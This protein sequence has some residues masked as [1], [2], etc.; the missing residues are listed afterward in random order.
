M[1]RIKVIQHL[2]V[3]LMAL[4]VA[5]SCGSGTDRAKEGQTEES[6]SD[7][8]AYTFEKFL[9]DAKNIQMNAA[10]ISSIHQYLVIARVDYFQEICNPP[11]NVN[12]YMDSYPFAAANLGVYFADLIYHTYARA[13]ENTANTTD[14]ILELADYI[15][16]ENDLYEGLVARYADNDVPIDSTLMY[17]NMLMKDSEKYGSESEKVFVKSAILLGNN[18]EKWYLVSTLIQIPFRR[19]IS[20]DEAT[21]A[22]QELTYF[23]MNLENRVDVLLKMAVAQRDQLKSV[24]LIEELEKLKQAATA[25]TASGDQILAL[26]APGIMANAEL[27]KLHEQLSVIRKA[28]ILE[29]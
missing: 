23:M 1:N 24:F 15:G 13:T 26:D 16:L 2:A 5:Y 10:S 9:E 25:V 29:Q 8:S 11:E 14:A 6:I 20:P 18:I 12:K 7:E 21:L 19:E 27:D 28:V 22:K 4:L 3:I 17:W